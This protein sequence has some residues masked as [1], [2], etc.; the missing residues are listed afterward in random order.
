[1]LCYVP[2]I[3]P[4]THHVPKRYFGAALGWTSSC[5]RSCYIGWKILI[6]WWR[7]TQSECLV[8]HQFR[9]PWS[10]SYLVT[11]AKMGGGACWCDHTQHDH[12][13]WA[14]WSSCSKEWSPYDHQSRLAIVDHQLPAEFADF[15]AMH[16]EIH[17]IPRC[18]MIWYSICGRLKETLSVLQV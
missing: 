4:N 11:W 6:S 2:V 14:R 9:N 3:L 5:S 10:Y 16:H 18:K 13:K 7:K 1:M 12:Q 17:I 15:L 8:P